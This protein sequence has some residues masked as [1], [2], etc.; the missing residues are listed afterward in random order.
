MPRAGVTGKTSRRL[1]R[2][3]GLGLAAV[4]AALGLAAAGWWIAFV[5]RSERVGEVRIDPTVQLDPHRTYTV[6]LWEA[7]LLLPWSEKRYRD[8]LEQAVA[9]FRRDYPNIEVRLTWRRLAEHGSALAEA[10]ARG[11]PPDVAAVA[12]PFHVLAPRLQ[13]PVDRYLTP[14]AS[15]D[16][17]PA[18]L[19]AV[20]AGQRTWGWPR[21]IELALWPGDSR[22]LRA[23][24]INPDAG[25][26]IWTA[27]QVVEAARRV[28]RRAVAAVDPGSGRV[29]AELLAAAGLPDPVTEDGRLEWTEDVLRQAGA[30]AL[31]LRAAVTVTARPP[32]SGRRLATL[33]EGR[34]FFLA[35]TSPWL[36]RHLLHRAGQRGVGRAGAGGLELAFLA[37]PP[38]PASP[39]A[40]STG[41][42]APPL[43]QP[44][45]VAAYAVFRQRP[46]RGHATV[47]AA[48]LLAEY[49]SRR[50]GPWVAERL[51]TLPAHRSALAAW[52]DRSPFGP[53]QARS[54][55][56]RLD[57]L[58]T[59]SPDA[60]VAELR[61][62]AITEVLPPAV[63]RL[64]DGRLD[65]DGFAREVAQRLEVLL[66]D[67][68]LSEAGPPPRR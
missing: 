25:P 40:G 2:T 29:I 62:R 11:A 8:E 10:V 30:F 32:A 37:P 36:I 65:A 56:E 12:A 41:A 43:R 38:L 50:M 19:A 24:G 45:A 64:W 31:Q 60:A 53:T 27:T 54:L 16:L 68:P 28:G 61:R 23:G 44:G 47:K 49:L 3:G 67:S 18:A 15:A 5:I 51:G 59:P 52:V 22:L 63:A 66:R 39:V 1:W 33:Q 55:A 34:A 7:D 13:V 57:R 42:A 46:Y 14:A 4:A 6:S 26:G 58:V 21:W 35:P 9:E 17:L 20:R 48:M